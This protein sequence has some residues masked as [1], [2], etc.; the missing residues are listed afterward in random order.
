MVCRGFIAGV[1]DS[2]C[3]DGRVLR[4]QGRLEGRLGDGGCKESDEGG[5]LLCRGWWWFL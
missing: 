2:G 4:V 1:G 3:G 5:R